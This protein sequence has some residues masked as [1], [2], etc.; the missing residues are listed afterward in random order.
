M[1]IAIPLGMLA[2]LGSLPYL[3]SQPEQTQKGSWFPQ[4]GR[5]AQ[6]ATAVLTLAWLILTLL[7]LLK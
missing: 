1:G 7:E 2:I 4:T 5:I 3:F 6:I